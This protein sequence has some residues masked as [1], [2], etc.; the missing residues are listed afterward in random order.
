MT[1]NISVTGTITLYSPG[2]EVVPIHFKV[3]KTKSLSDCLHCRFGSI[4]DDYEF[5]EFMAASTTDD[6]SDLVDV[7][8]PTAEDLDLYGHQPDIFIIHCSFD[9]KNCSYQ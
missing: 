9:K 6:Y 2:K 1:E 7:L 3:I 4:E 8:K 5:D